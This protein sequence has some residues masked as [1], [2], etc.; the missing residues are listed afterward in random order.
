MQ[1]LIR[2][3]NVN[4]HPPMFS[5]AMYYT[6]VEEN[7]PEGRSVL[8]VEATDQ[9]GAA[10]AKGTTSGVK[11]AITR[12][13][14]QSNFVIGEDDGHLMTGK[15]RLDRETQSEYEL[16]VRAC[17]QGQPQ[18]CSTTIVVVEVSDQNDNAPHFPLLPPGQKSASVDVPAAKS[19]EPLARVIAYDVDERGPNSEIE[20]SLVDS[21]SDFSIDQ[22][23]RIATTLPLKAGEKRTLHV[24]AAD[25]GQPLPR[26]SEMEV[27][28]TA[29][30]GPTK[31]ASRANKKPRLL[32][33]DLWQELFV[34]DSDQVGTAVGVIRAIDEDGDPLWWQIDD[35]TNPNMTFN[36]QAGTAVRP[37]GKEATAELVRSLFVGG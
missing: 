29:V 22:H 4:D 7:S 12:G 34:S 30:A 5:Q 18:L 3:L 17:D 2:V 10:S 14:P 8:R 31:G 25:K 21:S 35:A 27:S 11:Y 28:L 24:R 19:G 13:N 16:E 1:L 32:E 36:L 15:R 6:R 26:A 23:G 20:Y 37:R 33:K 9:D